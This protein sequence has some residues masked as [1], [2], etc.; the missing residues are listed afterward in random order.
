MN[1][2]GSWDDWRRPGLRARRLEDG[3]WEARLEPPPSGPHRYKFLLDDSRWL[4]DPA[5]PARAHDG[6][7]GW[8]SVVVPQ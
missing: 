6:L 4:T 3:V 8:N 1:V 5:N 7:G 2:V